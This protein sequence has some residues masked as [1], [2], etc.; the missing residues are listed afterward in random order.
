MFRERERTRRPQSQKPRR[1]AH[2]ASLT[3]LPPLVWA[4][5]LSVASLRDVWRVAHVCRALHALVTTYPECTC[6]MCG[7]PFGQWA[8]GRSARTR[9][10][11]EHL[12]CAWFG[13]DHIDEAWSQLTFAMKHA[14][15]PDRQ[16]MNALVMA[17]TRGHDKLV[18]LLL[19]DERTNPAFGDQRALRV[20]VVD[21]HVAVVDLLLRDARI[22]PGDFDPRTFRAACENGHLEVVDRLLREPRIDTK[23]T[24][25]NALA[26]ACFR[27]HL[28]VVER[29]LCESCI[30]PSAASQLALRFA[31]DEGRV[32]VV[33]RLL[34]DERV[35]RDVEALRGCIWSA[36]FYR[37]MDVVALLERCL[38]A[39]QTARL[40]E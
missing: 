7:A 18:R 11:W 2:M 31:V 1:C 12:R 32:A 37:H 38:N 22:F 28:N 4:T 25:Q 27:G 40:V 33:A 8:S 3:D 35:S 17:C 39:S 15:T 21:G 13:P 10:F 24:S 14:A 30:D 16:H 5:V 36:R 23:A 6:T 19:R 20:A 29:L 34:R 26:V 9:A